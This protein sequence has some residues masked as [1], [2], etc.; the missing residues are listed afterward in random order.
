MPLKKGHSREVV[1]HNIREMIHSGYKPKQA[2]A[3]SLASARKYKKMGYGGEVSHAHEMHPEEIHHHMAKGGM[4]HHDSSYAHGG[5]MHKGHDSKHS[6][7][8]HQHMKHMAHGGM[9]EHEDDAENPLS[10]KVTSGGLP[11]HESEAEMD[12]MG[13]EDELRSLNEIRKDGEYYPSEVANPNEMREAMHFAKAL[14]RMA[15]E[16]LSPEHLDHMAMGGLVQDGPA[17]DEPYGNKP[18]YIIDDGTEEPMSA[19]PMKPSDHF[20]KEIEPKGMGLSKEAMEAIQ[21][22]RKSRRFRA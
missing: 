11:R 18:E 3:A 15:M 9:M 4:V 2:V 21:K 17:G 13:P 6:R 14:H 20:K 7:A 5:M 12:R 1:A 22:K 8:S 10:H 16:Q 19:E